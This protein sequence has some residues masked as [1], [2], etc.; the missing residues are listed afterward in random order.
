MLLAPYVCYHIF[1]LGE[2]PH[3]GKIATHSACDMFSWYKYLTVNLVFSRLC[4]QKM[5]S[6][7]KFSLQE[8]EK[9]KLSNKQRKTRGPMV[10]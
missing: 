9:M 7:V 1:S 10:L 4:S 8:L 2:W 6:V 5:E 3:I